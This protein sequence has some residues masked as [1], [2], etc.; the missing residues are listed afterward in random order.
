V[1]V[2]DV[3]YGFDGVGCEV[4]RTN[5]LLGSRPLTTAI[6]GRRDTNL[7]LLWGFIGSSIDEGDGLSPQDDDYDAASAADKDFAYFGSVATTVP[8]YRMF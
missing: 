7:G 5:K 6:R 1:E 3:K 8:D 4:V 2:T